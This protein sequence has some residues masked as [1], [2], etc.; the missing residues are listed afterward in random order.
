[1]VFVPVTGDGDVRKVLDTVLE[2]VRGWL[3]EEHPA[4]SRLVV[5]TSGAV[6]TEA[7]ADVP[8]LAAAAAWGL[9]RTAAAEHPDRFLLLDVEDPADQPGH[10]RAV[11][12]ALAAGEDQVAVRGGRLL[13]PRLAPVPAEAAGPWSV[14]GGTVLITGGTGTLGRLVARHLAE[15]G[16][17]RL[18]LLSRR[19][20]AAPG[21]AD[22]VSSLTELGAEVTVV[23]CDVADRARLAEVLADVP[24]EHPLTAVVHAAGALDDGVVDALTPDR[25]DTVLRAKAD[26]AWHLHELTRELD[27]SA[28]VL[29]SSAAGTFGTPGQGNY[30][31]ANAYLDALARHRRAHGLPAQ[32]LA[33]GLWADTSELTGTL[34]P[35]GRNRLRRTGARAFTAE[36]G[37]AALDLAVATDEPVL[38]PVQLD[39]A[40]L[41]PR[42]DT[43]VPPLLRGLVRAPLRRSAA[44]GGDGADN[45]R[46]QL[47]GLAPDDR[48]RALLTLVRAQAATVLGHAGSAAVEP[49]RGFLDLGFDSLTAVEL[50][51]R[52][53]AATGLRLPATLVFDHPTA[54]ALAAFLAERLGAA[55]APALAP[56]LAELSRLETTLAPF[57]GDGDARAAITLRLKD[58]LSR[59]SAGPGHDP[60]DDPADDIDSA[61]DDEL[62]GVLDELR[63]P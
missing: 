42:G 14:E 5:V 1:V 56:A 3:G 11:A 53:Q 35:T 38:V 61:T 30:A 54:N 18:I 40:A 27:L 55:G 21:A 63:T 6:A 51:N 10:Q 57:T 13:V 23:A 32:S 4:G 50:R 39:P 52:L 62:F 47:A 8:D 9:L 43:G 41:R 36:A 45:L 59:W 12:A 46:R 34:D 60:A 44:G 37:L 2:S 16:A 22:V 7:T 20:Y 17:R 28:F 15:H 48:T 19:G 49:G 33:W 58:L 24:P 25:I 31:G 29:F 26:P